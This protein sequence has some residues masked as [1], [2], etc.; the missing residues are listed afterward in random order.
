MKTVFQV[1]D[2]CFCEYKL[3]QIMEME[4]DQVTSVSDGRFRHSGSSLND[5]CFPLDL[6]VK[7]ISDTVA[8]YMDDLHRERSVNLNYPDLNRELIRRWAAL[9]QVKDD[10][11][12]L[13]AGYDSLSAFMRSVRESIQKVKYEQV[14]GVSLFI[15]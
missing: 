9:C 14:E 11:E 3:Q 1:G 5:R 12:A 4:G 13:R 6:R 2:W 7:N 8:A 15:R 10:D